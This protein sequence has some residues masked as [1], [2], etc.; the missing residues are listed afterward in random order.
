MRPLGE[1]ERAVMDALW[2]R[3]EPATVRDVV[4]DL[5]ERRLAYNTVMTVLNRLAAKELVT[6]TMDGRTGYYTP[7][8][9][10]E[11]YIAE[12]ML[13]A[14]QLTGDRAAALNHFAR[15][16]ERPDAAALRDALTEGR[17]RRSR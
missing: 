2:Q 15:T 6:R 12:L 7:A 13:Q 10:R 11:A 8:A 16:I 3:G 5:A 1:L 4:D 14:L 17:P 9:S